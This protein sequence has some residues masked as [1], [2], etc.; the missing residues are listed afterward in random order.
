MYALSV[1]LLVCYA[2]DCPC[3]LLRC[4]QHVTSSEQVLLKETQELEAALE[5]KLTV[6]LSRTAQRES[7]GYSITTPSI[8]LE[9]LISIFSPPQGRGGLGGEAHT[10]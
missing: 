5:K 7:S 2:H 6:T 4:V 9:S 3:S 1:S 8:S 10:C